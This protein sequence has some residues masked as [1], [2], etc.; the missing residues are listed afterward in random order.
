MLEVVE[1]LM[2]QYAYE[3]GLSSNLKPK[4]YLWTDAFAVCNFLEL[5]RRTSN[6]TYL[7]LAIKLVDQVHYVLGRHREDDVRRGWISGLSDEDGFKHPTI[8]GLRIGKPLP[9]RRPDEPYDDELEW[10]RDGQ[11]YHYLTKWM[12]ALNRV[13]RATSNPTYIVWAI[14]LAKT[15]HR[16]FV[17][18]DSKG[19]KRMYW[20]MSI[21]LSRPLVPSMGLHDPLDGLI[22]YMELAFNAPDN[23]NLSL[24]NEIEEMREMCRG[25][26]WV[27]NDPLGAGELLRCAHSLAKLIAMKGL[28]EVGLLVDILSSALTSLELS[29][30][31]GFLEL[32]ASVR[33]AFRELGL[34][35]GLKA[36]ERML[37]LIEVCDALKSN[38][39]VRSTLRVLASYKWIASEIERYWLKPLNMESESWIKHKEINTV[40][41]ATSLM[42][43]EFLGTY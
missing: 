36:V 34:S 41:L 21:D 33:L 42:P 17:Y 29:L 27:T 15:A 32:P 12:H 35:I 7:E 26:D 19:R 38:S 20:K 5:W 16:A 43:D 3:T 37:N 8:G 13:Y 18:T 14:E 2:L 24:Q 10:E 25:M 31:T 9:E 6:A 39:D 28:D 4:R 30:S 40:M 11:Y 1:K 23:L 22:T